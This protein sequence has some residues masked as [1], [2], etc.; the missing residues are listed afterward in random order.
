M[1]INI[2]VYLGIIF[3]KEYADLEKLRKKLA[4]NLTVC[5]EGEMMEKPPLG[6]T[7][8][9][10][11]DNMRISEIINAVYRY[12]DVRKEIPEEWIKEYNELCINLNK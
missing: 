3:K 5:G 8:K 4:V 10:I 7:P 2:V 1:G 6:L 11:H 12:M 9:Y